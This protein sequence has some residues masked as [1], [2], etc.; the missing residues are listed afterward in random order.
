MAEESDFRRAVL[1][2]ADRFGWKVYAPQPKHKPQGYTPKGWPDLTLARRGR[3]VF[4][5]LKKQKGGTV[6]TEQQEW[7]DELACVGAPQMGRGPVTAAIVRPDDL[8]IIAAWLQ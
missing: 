7:I 2:L 4:L 6:T 8:S 5:E 3:I 1:D